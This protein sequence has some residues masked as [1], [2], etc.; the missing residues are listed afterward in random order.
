MGYLYRLHDFPHAL[1]SD[2]LQAW[3]CHKAAR[4][5]NDSPDDTTWVDVDGSAGQGGFGSAATI[6]KPDGKTWSYIKKQQ[7]QA[8][9]QTKQYH[10]SNQQ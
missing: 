3:G 6:F 4:L 5:L 7:E 2:D 9:A 1:R 10:Q 8:E